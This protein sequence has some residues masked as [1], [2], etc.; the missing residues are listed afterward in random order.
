MKNKTGSCKYLAF[1]LLTAALTATGMSV[2]ANA[3]HQAQEPS[4]NPVITTEVN[5][6]YPFGIRIV[7]GTTVE[8]G[9]V[10]G[11]LLV[12]L[13]KL[14]RVELSRNS[15]IKLSYSE[16]FIEGSLYAG[17]VRVS[18]PAGVSANISTTDGEVVANEGGATSFTIDMSC[19]ATV[20]KVKNGEVQLRADGEVK[21]I[22]AGA[23]SSVGTPL[24]GKKCAK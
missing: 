2:P 10:T 1:C 3:G 6:R 7:S 22:S 9:N 19:G 16:N 21:N 24:A 20:V 23:Q 5:E 14:G 11:G 15:K 12:N 18:I 17:R 8:A 4:S 13:G